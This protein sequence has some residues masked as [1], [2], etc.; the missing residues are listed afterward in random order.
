MWAPPLEC[1]LSGT[2]ILG[3]LLIAAGVVI[4]DILATL[5]LNRA[6]SRLDM[7]LVG[8][9]TGSVPASWAC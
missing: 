6:A 7:V 5:A 1:G 3:I 4:G 9:A 2:T 8:V